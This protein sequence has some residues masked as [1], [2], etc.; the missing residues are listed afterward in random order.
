MEHYSPVLGTMAERLF[1]TL[2]DLTEHRRSVATAFQNRLATLPAL[3]LIQPPAGAR[4][5]WLRFPILLDTPELR[6]RLLAALGVAGCGATG[7]YPL[8]TF[9]I[10]EISAHLDIDRSHAGAGR[11]IAA[12]I[13]TLPTHPYVKPKHV[14]RICSIIKNELFSSRTCG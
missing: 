13:L 10:P 4:P 5:V 11:Y 8:S 7:S 1:R 3:R 14:D 9:D 6:E 12:R 2:E